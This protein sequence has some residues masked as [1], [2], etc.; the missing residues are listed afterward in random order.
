MGNLKFEDDFTQNAK[1]YLDVTYGADGKYVSSTIS[2]GTTTQAA[3]IIGIAKRK[4]AELKFPPSDDGGVSTILLN[5]K[6]QN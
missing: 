5:F 1:V 3:N 4:A 2:K 6:V